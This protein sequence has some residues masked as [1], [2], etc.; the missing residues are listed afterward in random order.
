[1]TE[2][3]PRIAGPDY[4]YAMSMNCYVVTFGLDKL[5]NYQNESSCIAVC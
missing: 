3:L 1:M 4:N 5:L 2:R